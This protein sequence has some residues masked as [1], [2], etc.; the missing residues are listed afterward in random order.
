[1]RR[2]RTF[3]KSLLAILLAAAVLAAFWTGRV[4]APLNPLRPIDLSD[5]GGILRDFR[6]AALERAPQTCR[7]ILRTPHIEAVPIADSPLQ[8]GCGWTNSYRVTAAGGARLGADRLSCQMSAALALWLTHAVQPLAEQTFGVR[9]AS[10]EVMGTY[11]CRNILGNTFW[12]GLRSEHARANAIDI[13]GFTL[14]DGRPVS[15]A[16]HWRGDGNE[17]LFLREAHRRACRYF[18]VSLS[19]AFNVSHKDH[20]HFDRGLLWQCK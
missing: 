4:P 1:M 19:P 15:V 20:F 17:A 5:P 9:V 8:A 14:A 18:R 12:K 3:L 7:A 16:R 2:L 6:L 10:V 11:S 13:A